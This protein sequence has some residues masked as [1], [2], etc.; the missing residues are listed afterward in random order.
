MLAALVVLAHALPACLG[1]RDD[2]KLNPQPLPP[3][4]P[5]RGTGETPVNN[6]DGD[7]NGAAPPGGMD[8]G[9]TTDGDA[10]DHDGGGDR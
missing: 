7:G 2:T 6:G 9:S 5:G 4:E 10:A 8:A 1:D 3:G